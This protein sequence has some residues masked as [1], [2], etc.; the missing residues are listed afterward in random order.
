MIQKKCN[1]TEFTYTPAI[2]KWLSEDKVEG[3]CISGAF[4][5]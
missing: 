5:D 2:L 3:F 4:Q 1:K